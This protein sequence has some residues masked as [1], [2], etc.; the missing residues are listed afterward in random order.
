MG[1]PDRKTVGLR[2]DPEI[3]DKLERA[4]QQLSL[5]KSDVANLI[6]RQCDEVYFTLHAP[7][8]TVTLQEVEDFFDEHAVP[9]PSDRVPVVGGD[10]A[11][12]V[13]GDGAEHPS[14]PYGPPAEHQQGQDE[15]PGQDEHD[16]AMAAAR[17]DTDA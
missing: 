8:E 17:G 15:D 14:G 4:A 13:F 3:D 10:N 2:L 5:S 6:I 9:R 12:E 11:D 16:A 7:G 1:K